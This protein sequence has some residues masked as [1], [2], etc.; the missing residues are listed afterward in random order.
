[1]AFT[2]NGNTVQ[3]P[4]H[5][6]L[7]FLAFQSHQFVVFC[8]SRDS[9]GVRVEGAKKALTLVAKMKCLNRLVAIVAV[10][11]FPA[12]IL[13]GQDVVLKIG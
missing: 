1:M 11:A 3:V 7:A 10:V 4:S 12:E 6:A 13:Q 2:S 5:G 9:V 8:A